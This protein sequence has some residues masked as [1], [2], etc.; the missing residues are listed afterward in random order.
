VRRTGQWYTAGMISQSASRLLADA[1]ITT[2]A[3]LRGQ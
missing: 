2:M 3:R 1:P